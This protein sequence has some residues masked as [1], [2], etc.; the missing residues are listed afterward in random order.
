M[1]K[2]ET[3]N[4]E[5]IWN[6]YYDHLLIFIL[7]RVHDKATA[8]DILQN[9]FLKILTNLKS[10]K[11]N[12]KLKSWL[13]QITRNAI[14]DFYRESK[15]VQEILID[16]LD[17]EEKSAINVT[18][19]VESWIYPFILMLPEKYREAL[20]LSEIKG[21]SQKDLASFMGIS[22]PA[23]KSRVQRGRALL[24][25]KLTDCCI[26]YTDKYGNVMDYRQNPQN[27]NSCSS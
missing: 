21:M 24:K 10:L 7:K 16:V 5:L 15:P 3:N 19:E 11:D 23:A 14:I 8:E 1:T 20:I 25:T 4:I 17:E 9:V 22:Y 6:D 27:C 2:K 12:T 18:E 13:F 26:F